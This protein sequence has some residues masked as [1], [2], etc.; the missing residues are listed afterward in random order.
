[1]QNYTLEE[2]RF[3]ISKLEGEKVKI[4]E[5]LFTK[6]IGSTVKSISTNTEGKILDINKKSIKLDFIFLNN[7]ATY[8]SINDYFKYIYADDETQKNIVSYLNI[9]H[10]LPYRDNN[11]E[12]NFWKRKEK[13][14][15]ENEAVL[16]CD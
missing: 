7:S 15:L 4:K 13:A 8:I 6:I 9:N 3:I 14:I 10:Y 2:I 1:M 11:K 5:D 12:L 16:K